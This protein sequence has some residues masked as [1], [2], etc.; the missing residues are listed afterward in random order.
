MADLVC[1]LETDPYATRVCGRR[2]RPQRLLKRT[3]H[4]SD[5]GAPKY[6]LRSIRQIHITSHNCSNR[7]GMATNHH[8]RPAESSR[9]SSQK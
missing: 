1:Y 9:L 5:R 6:Q 2:C 3:S 4:G 8:S 7:P